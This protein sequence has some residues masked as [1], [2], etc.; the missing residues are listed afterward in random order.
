[1]NKFTIF[2]I[3]YSTFVVLAV[4]ARH[5]DQTFS[6]KTFRTFNQDDEGC[7]LDCGNNGVCLFKDRREKKNPACLCDVDYGT[8]P[9]ALCGF[10][11]AS[12][13]DSNKQC[14]EI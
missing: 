7:P 6:T 8:F 4:V 12:T 14:F 13:L 11:T 10:E 9:E 2:A 1:M 3:L 5:E